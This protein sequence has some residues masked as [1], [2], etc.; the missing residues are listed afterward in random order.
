MVGWGGV[1]NS[2]F[3]PPNVI[4][5]VKILTHEQ[6]LLQY[7][8]PPFFYLLSHLPTDI[9]LFFFLLSPAYPNTH[10]AHPKPLNRAYHL[11]SSWWAELSVFMASLT[12]HQQ[13]ILH[14]WILLISIVSFAI[15]FFLLLLSHLSISVAIIFSGSH[16]T[17]KL[18][19]EI[20]ISQ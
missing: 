3:F 13:F 10:L 14:F 8:L 17:T 2:F 4:H 15:V 20:S 11:P 1:F 12:Y 5:K 6:L 18:F 19:F 16:I 9:V 7:L